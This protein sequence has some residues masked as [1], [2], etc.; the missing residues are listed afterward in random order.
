[1]QMDMRAPSHARVQWSVSVDVES[2]ARD[3]HTVHSFVVSFEDGTVQ[4]FDARA[5]TSNSDFGLKLSFTLHA[6]DKAVCAVSYNP[7]MAALLAIG[8]TDK[9]VKLWNITNGQLAL[10]A[11]FTLAFAEDSPSLLAIGG[12]KWKLKIWDTSSNT[13][14]SKAK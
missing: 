8:S 11:I 4:S 3:P 10:G 1:M 13:S 2:L 9:T 14:I 5:A 12:S 7:S 6:H